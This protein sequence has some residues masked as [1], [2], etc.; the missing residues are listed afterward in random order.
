MV[1][2]TLGTVRLSS[3]RRLSPGMHITDYDTVVLA[4]N[5]SVA[6][7]KACKRY[8]ESIVRSIESEGRYPVSMVFL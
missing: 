7:V 1:L 8:K 5:S 3:G 4:S 2:Y 6:L